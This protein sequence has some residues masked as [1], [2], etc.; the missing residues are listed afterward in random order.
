MIIMKGISFLI[1]NKIIIFIWYI[2]MY[3]NKPE[4]LDDYYNLPYVPK[5]GFWF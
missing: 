5:V 4:A 1:N 2:C 3:I